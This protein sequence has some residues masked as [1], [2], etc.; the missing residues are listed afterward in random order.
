MPSI[1]ARIPDDEEDALMEVAELLDQDKSS[2]I[3]KAL[4]EGL[5]DIRVRVAIQRYQ[6]GELSMK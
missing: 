5:H 2:V 3:W 6:S 4:R 1:S